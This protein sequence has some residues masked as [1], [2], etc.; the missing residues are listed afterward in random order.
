M[1]E[2]PGHAEPGGV[3][4]EELPRWRDQVHA[5]VVPH[6]HDEAAEPCTGAD[7]R[8]TVALPTEALRL[9][10]TAPV[11]ADRVDRTRPLAGPVADHS[12]CDFTVG[13]AA[14]ASFFAREGHLEVPRGHAAAASFFAREGHL[15]VPR[16]HVESIGW[17]G[18]VEEVKLGVWVTNTRVR[19]AKLSV[20][21]VTGLDAVGMRWT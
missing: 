3:G 21:R 17:D 20:E 1:G 9:V 19:C 11:L 4:L 2:R 18:G 15:E 7:A 12:G 6:E 8:V 16:G 13:V 10:L 5:Q 14:A